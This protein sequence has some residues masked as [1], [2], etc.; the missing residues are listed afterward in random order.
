MMAWCK[1][2]KLRI[3]CW[4]GHLLLT[5]FITY[6]ILRSRVG[7]ERV[8]ADFGLI[9]PRLAQFVLSWWY[10]WILPVLAI[11]AV[12]KEWF[13]NSRRAA[14]I[15]NGIHLLITMPFGNCISMAFFW[16]LIGLVERLSH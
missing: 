8:F 16:T 6:E 5:V 15:W 3:S 7:F 14:L 2:C 1:S 11:V 10:P 9:L 13:L 4:R 12:A